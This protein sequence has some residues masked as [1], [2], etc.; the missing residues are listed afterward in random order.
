MHLN[1]QRGAL[2][3]EVDAADQLVAEQERQHVVPVLTAWRRRVD[4]DR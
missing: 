1:E 4:L 3:A 2:S